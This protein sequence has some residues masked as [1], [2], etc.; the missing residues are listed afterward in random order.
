MANKD[1]FSWFE[2]SEEYITSYRQLLKYYKQINRLRLK[3][4]PQE[5]SW[6][7]WKG[8]IGKLND[9]ACVVYKH[10]NKVVAFTYKIICD[11]YDLLLYVIVDEKYRDKGMVIARPSLRPPPSAQ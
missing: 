9:I 8:F 4:F 11:N 3:A 1:E 6:K 5:K 7:F 10:K 2:F